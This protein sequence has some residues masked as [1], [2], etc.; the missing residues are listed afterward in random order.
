[1]RVAAQRLFPADRTTRSLDFQFLGQLLD[2]LEIYLAAVP[3]D[4][5]AGDLNFTYPS[6]VLESATKEV[7]ANYCR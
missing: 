5:L 7:I 3:P 6:R 1:M 2:L 4:Y